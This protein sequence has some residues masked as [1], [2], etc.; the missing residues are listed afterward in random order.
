MLFITLFLLLLRAR[1][2][3]RGL[4]LT[5]HSLSQPKHSF[6]PPCVIINY[7][8]ACYCMASMILCLICQW[9]AQHILIGCC[10]DFRANISDYNNTKQQ[11]KLQPKSRENKSGSPFV[12]KYP[13]LLGLSWTKREGA[14]VLQSG[15][16]LHAMVFQH[17]SKA[18]AF[19]GGKEDRVS[20]KYP[21]VFT[22]SL[23][24]LFGKNA[25]EN[26]RGVSIAV[27]GVTLRVLGSLWDKTKWK[28]LF[29]PSVT[30]TSRNN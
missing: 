19:A 30:N 14:G 1:T 28:S 8:A 16:C 11:P 22:F 27:P 4:C 2:R 6:S 12:Q 26:K 23:K 10:L 17:V 3:I 25:R 9:K 24:C 5:S 21:R 18:S 13:C 7:L 20:S 15:K 29:V